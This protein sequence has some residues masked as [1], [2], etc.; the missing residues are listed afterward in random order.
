MKLITKV[1]SFYELYRLSESDGKLLPKNFI[2]VLL[3]IIKGLKM[4][5]NK[6]LEVEEEVLQ[7]YLTKAYFH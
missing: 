1:N 3:H 7:S 2:R 5:F 6:N 4:H